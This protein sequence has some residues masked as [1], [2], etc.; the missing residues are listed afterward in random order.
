MK[1][2]LDT[3][4]SL[5][6]LADGDQLGRDARGLIA[7]PRTEVIV[8]IVSLW[9]IAVKIRVGKLQADIKEVWDA[10]HAAKFSVIGVGF[11]HLIA[12]VPLP[13]LH[14]DPFD[15]LLMAQAEAEGA[16]LMSSDRHVASYPIRQI[17]CGDGRKPRPR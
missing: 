5:W 10:V 8:S 4:A 13:M 1:L 3:N 11:S 6:W 2:L 14:R 17:A 7:D 12:L 16:V 9:E 15:R